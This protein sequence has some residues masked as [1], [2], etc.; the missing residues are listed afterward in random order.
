MKRYAFLLILFFCLLLSSCATNSSN[1]SDTIFTGP[2]TIE[3]VNNSKLLENDKENFNY[4]INRLDYYNY[5]SLLE[6]FS[7]KTIILRGAELREEDE[8]EQQQRKALDEIAAELKTGILK[9][10]VYKPGLSSTITEAWKNNPE[11]QEVAAL[12]FYYAALF[13]EDSNDI[14]KAKS[15]IRKI[16]PSYQGLLSQEI[17]DFGVHLLGSLDNWEKEHLIG[18]EVLERQKA[19]ESGDLKLSIE[20]YNWIE[21]RYDYYDQKEGGYAGD[22]YSKTIYQEAANQFG[23]TI[24]EI[25]SIRSDYNVIEA[26]NQYNESSQPSLTNNSI[27]YDATLV[28]GDGSVVIFVDEKAMDD[29]F[30]ALNQGDNDKINELE[31]LGQIANVPKGTKCKI[32]KSGLTRY[33]VEIVEGIYKGNTVWVIRESVIRK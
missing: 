1:V 14:E 15:E 26:A 23:I 7:V 9:D 17:Q 10:G 13:W 27:D 4:A 29:F 20:I 19:R 2:E 33:Q 11:N 31:R 28:Y 16:D 6:G 25:D 12:Y 8:R 32:V 22:K 24:E 21:Q 18:K 30:R 3:I 5:P